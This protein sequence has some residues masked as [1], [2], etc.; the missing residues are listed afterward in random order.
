V[1]RFTYS[2]QPIN[3]L[4]PEVQ[5]TD[6]STAKYTIDQWYWRFAEGSDSIDLQQNP[7]HNY[8]DT[9][10]F[11]ATLIVVDEHG[12]VDSVTNC[13]V[14][15][16]LFTFYI[17]DAFT[18]NGDGINDVFMPKGSYVKDYEMYIY[19]RWGMQLFH[20]TD[21]TNGWNGGVD[22]GSR[23]CQEDT[24]I[25]LI[26]VTDSQGNGHSYTGTLNLIK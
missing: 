11:C 16:P 9:G 20:S 6:E 14:V 23:T 19:D 21:I 4:N 12:C 13:L 2:P 22:N 15:N 24:Y 25:Y 17:P 3:I 10:T 7:H 1:A 26:K 5:F 18:P 8:A